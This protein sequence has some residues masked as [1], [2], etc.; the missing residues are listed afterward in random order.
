VLSNS[1]DEFEDSEDVYEAIGHVLEE[2]AEDKSEGEIRSAWH[3]FNP[4]PFFNPF[5][6]LYL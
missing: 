4:A 3:A 5:F 2:V 6:A 1:A